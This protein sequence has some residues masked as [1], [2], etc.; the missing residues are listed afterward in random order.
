MSRRRATWLA[1]GGVLVVVLVAA[2]AVFEPWLLVVDRTA[3]DGDEPAAVVGTATGGLADTTVPS[4]PGEELT[5]VVL[6]SAY[7][8]DG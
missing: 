1:T 7:F 8:V 6:A 3:D 4:A 5:R 2:L